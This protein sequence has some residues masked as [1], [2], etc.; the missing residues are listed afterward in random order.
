MSSLDLRLAALAKLV[1]IKSPAVDKR[2]AEE[3]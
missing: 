1:D 3:F 2:L